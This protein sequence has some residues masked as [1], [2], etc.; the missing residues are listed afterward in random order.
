MVA[1][2]S[3][4]GARNAASSTSKIFLEKLIRFGQICLDLGEIWAKLRRN[5]GKIERKLGQK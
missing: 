2:C 3:T 4:V 5:S 1:L